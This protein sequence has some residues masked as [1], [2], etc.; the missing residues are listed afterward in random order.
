MQVIFETERLYLREFSDDDFPFLH[1]IFSDPETMR[2]YPAP[3]SVEQTK[4]WIARNK[5]RYEKDGF[6]LWA[7]CLKETDEVIGDCGL[8]KQ[9]VD[10]TEEVEIGYHINKKYWSKG[11]AS[12]A[13]LGTREYGIGRLRL[14]RLISIIGPENIPSIRVAEKIGF[15]LEKES[16]IFNK[17]HLIYAVSQMDSPNLL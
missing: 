14:K 2:H 4:N 11:Y 16:F 3:F 1:E 9:T 15:T 5:L 12:E 6:G 7:V 8:V 10:G 13:A 17:I